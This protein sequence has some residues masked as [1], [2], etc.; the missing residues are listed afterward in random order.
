MCSAAAMESWSENLEFKFSVAFPYSFY[1]AVLI[2][3]R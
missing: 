1:D 2:H 3:T